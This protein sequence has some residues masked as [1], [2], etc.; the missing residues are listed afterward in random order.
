MATQEPG[1]ERKLVDECVGDGVRGHETRTLGE[2]KHLFR[3]VGCGGVTQIRELPRVKMMDRPSVRAAE[4]VRTC[5]TCNEEGRDRR[6]V[7]ASVEAHL[8]RFRECLDRLR[9]GKVLLAL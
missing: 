6:S 2:V 9:I 3:C 1:E 4:P 5:T 7:W 8:R